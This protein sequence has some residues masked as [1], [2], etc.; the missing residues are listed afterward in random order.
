MGPASSLPRPRATFFRRGLARL[1][2]RWF[3][4]LLLTVSSWAANDAPPPRD[5]LLSAAI[6]RGQVFAVGERG[7]L[8]RSPDSGRHWTSV[9]SP[10]SATLTAI[11]F[12][13]DETHG[14]AVGHDGVI[15]G[16]TDA[17]VSWRVVYRTASVES[18]FLDVCV[19]DATHIFAVGAYGLFVEKHPGVPDW[20]VRRLIDD[21]DHFNRLARSPAG[22]LYLAGERGTL[23]RSRDAGASWQRLRSP[24]DGSFFGVL[25]LGGSTLLIYG[26]SGRLFR[27]ADDGDTWQRIP[28]N[29]SALLA[30]A[31]RLPDGAIFLAGQAPVWLVSRDDGRSV[32]SCSPPATMA[33][34]QLLLAPDGTLLA[35]GES[36]AQPLRLP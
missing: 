15:L 24:Y 10:T 28:T 6:A 33:V 16:T 27:S 12:A 17:G 34:A 4:L 9:P 18:S 29:A 31:V 8:Y 26:L 30:T 21:D 20:T 13:P 19:L 36:G 35:F 32:S 7:L 11:A 1:V 2:A 14:W 23:L 5:L 22:T 25:P 3:P